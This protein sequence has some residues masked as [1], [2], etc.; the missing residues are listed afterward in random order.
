MSDILQD[1]LSFR[2]L[3]VCRFPTIGQL[4]APN[5]IHLALEGTGEEQDTTTQSIVDTLR[6]YP[7]SS[8]G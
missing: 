1:F 3:F 6:A 8:Y 7:P 5:L 4:T 2:E